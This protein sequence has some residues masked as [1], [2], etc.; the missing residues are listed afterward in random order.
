MWSVLILT[1]KSH[2]R[3]FTQPHFCCFHA[4][5][6]CQNRINNRF[7]CRLRLQKPSL[8]RSKELPGLTAHRCF[9]LTSCPRV[10]CDVCCVFE[11][12]PQMVD[13]YFFPQR[14]AASPRCWKNN[15]AEWNKSTESWV[16]FFFFNLNSREYKIVSSVGT[17]A[18]C[19]F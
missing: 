2:I 16:F 4:A 10:W 11:V 8:C 14:L 7:E 1:S 6:L 3:I 5:C 18:L 19:C 15:F 9:R 17:C 13:F 12:L